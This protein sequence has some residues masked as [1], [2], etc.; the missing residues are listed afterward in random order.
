MEGVFGNFEIE[1]E[2]LIFG[3]MTLRNKFAILQDQGFVKKMV[4]NH[5]FG[6]MQ[7]E[8]QGVSRERLSKIY[9]SSHKK[10]ATAAV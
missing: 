1:F 4:I 10:I 6:T 5:A 7:L 3:A 2:Y 8:K 9:L